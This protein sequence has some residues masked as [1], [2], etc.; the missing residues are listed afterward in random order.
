MSH[1]REYFDGDYD[2]STEDYL[3]LSNASKA[4]IRRYFNEMKDPL[5]IENITFHA[6]SADDAYVIPFFEQCKNLMTVDLSD[7]KITNASLIALFKNCPN[8]MHLSIDECHGLNTIDI[9]LGCTKLVQLNVTNC[10]YVT[11]IDSLLKNS[12]EMSELYIDNSPKLS[13]HTFNS[14]IK[15]CPELFFISFTGEESNLQVLKKAFPDLHY[16]CYTRQGTL[17]GN[18]A[19]IVSIDSSNY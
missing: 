3:S 16:I 19:S 2:S 18:T 10:P 6:S 7:T 14:I 8:L 4:K 15:Y 1:D 13:P 12:P 5:E 11:S 17:R 9:S